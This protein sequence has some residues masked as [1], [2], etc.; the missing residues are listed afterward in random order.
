MNKKELS[1]TIATLVIIACTAA[2]LQFVQQGR[3]LGEPGVRLSRLPVMNDDG[4]V[5]GTNSIYMPDP[6]EGWGVQHFAVS[7]MEHE[8]LP[9]DTT[10]GRQIYRGPGHFEVAISAVLMGTDRTSIHKPQY[11]LS[12]QGWAITKTEVDTLRMTRPHPYDLK[13]MKLTTAMD[14]MVQGQQQ[15]VHGIYVYWF[16][17]DGL[18][19]PHHGERMW[20]MARD[21]ITKGTLQRW[22]Y[23]TYFTTCYPGQEDETYAK[24][25]DFIRET[26]PEFQL[27]SGQPA[28]KSAASQAAPDSFATAPAFR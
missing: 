19:T 20:W 8:W 12:G 21:L 9:K 26:T 27:A 24:L 4:K 7:D 16:V 14:V 22:A 17:A 15:R 10:Y 23:I 3:K 28:E 1:I 25:T 5:I 6:G 13:V 11:C 18:L 2:L